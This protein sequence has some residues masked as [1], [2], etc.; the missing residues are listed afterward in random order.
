MSD[1]FGDGLGGDGY[2]TD[3]TLS[4][5]EPVEGLG[6]GGDEL[7]ADGE[8][9]V[10]VNYNG[11]EF[12][13]GVAT[14]D[15]DGDGHNDT[16]VQ[17]TT[18]DEG[19]DQV[20]YYVDNSGDGIAD[21]IVIADEDGNLISNEVIDPE[22]GQFVEADFTGDLTADGLTVPELLD[23]DG[24][25]NGGV[26]DNGDGTVDI[27]LPPVPTVPD[28]SDV[29]GETDTA[30]PS[31]EEPTTGAEP[32]PEN[33]QGDLDDNF[34][35]IT[36]VPAETAEPTGDPTGITGP[37]DTE[38]AEPTETETAEPTGEATSGTEDS[39]AEDS[40]TEDAGLSLSD[41]KNDVDELTDEVVGQD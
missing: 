20:E 33:L 13:A 28:V 19:V 32:T 22:T 7:E 11:T 27:T 34:D 29:T 23:P 31:T 4:T 39:G 25:A 3:D 24:P 5:S 35:G 16:A 18:T 40:A 12:D 21:E 41:V 6:I 26:V 10:D 38:T 1:D 9:H 37:T 8:W 2:T 17:H 30:G 14:I 15:A 36:D